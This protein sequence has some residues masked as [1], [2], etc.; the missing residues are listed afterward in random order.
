M[1]NFRLGRS[2]KGLGAVI[3]VHILLNMVLVG[4][5]GKVTILDFLLG[6][7]LRRFFKLNYRFTTLNTYFSSLRLLTGTTLG[8]L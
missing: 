2:H 3:G 6:L 8:V 1:G 4:F 7:T 5:R